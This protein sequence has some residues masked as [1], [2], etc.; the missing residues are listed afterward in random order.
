MG[1]LIFF[2]LAGLYLA[3]NHADAREPL[4]QK[5]N[6]SAVELKTTT[7]K[8]SERKKIQRK[9]DGTLGYRYTCSPSGFGQMG[10]CW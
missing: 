7:S 2:T 10:K 8:K 9:P 6:K 1:I 4:N 3:T 5:A